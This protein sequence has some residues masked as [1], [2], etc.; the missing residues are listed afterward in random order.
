VGSGGADVAG[1]PDFPPTQS[2]V[3]VYNLLHGQLQQAET[4]FND[5]YAKDVPAFNDAMGKHGVE[6]LMTVAVK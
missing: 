3:E 2:E 5:F 1:N 6:K 4:Q